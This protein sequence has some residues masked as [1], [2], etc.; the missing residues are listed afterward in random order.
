MRKDTARET[1]P[2]HTLSIDAYQLI[3]ELH[4]TCYAPVRAIDSTL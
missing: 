2:L 4:V 3:D 1:L